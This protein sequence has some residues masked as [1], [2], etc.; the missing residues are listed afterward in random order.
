MHIL[1]GNVFFSLHLCYYHTNG[2]SNRLY[3]RTDMKTIKPFLSLVRKM[4]NAEHFGFYELILKY[5]DALTLKPAALQP[6]WDAFRAVFARED[7]IYKYRQGQE[8]TRL[9]NEAHRE[10]KNA[11]M[12][13][14][15]T[16]G[17]SVYSD[18]PAL[19][20]AA[21]GLVRILDNYP[22]IYQASLTEASAMIVN[23]VQDLLLPACAPAVAL[24]GAAGA[25]SR[26]SAGNDAFMT[27]YNERTYSGG[28]DRE[29]GSLLSARKRTDSEFSALSSAIM[30]FYRV[31]EVQQSGDPEVREAL[32]DLI[33][34]LNSHIA[35]HE[36]IY[37]RRISGGCHPGR[38]D[39]PDA[40]AEPA[41]PRRT[42]P[43]L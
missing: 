39:A 14:K 7:A 13:L 11:Y 30:S 16:I 19:K 34:F 2:I 43:E 41:E 32:A 36:A 25:I 31:N 20:D 1:P 37:A 9:L 3:I 8:Y 21:D 12:A 24:V 22:Y 40:P 28:E 33:L 35:R 23:L 17:V 38:E 26:L 10:R 29:K 15:R 27:L 18:T 6:V 4:R 5:G 42:F